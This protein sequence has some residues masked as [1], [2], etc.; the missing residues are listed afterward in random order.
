MRHSLFCG[1]TAVLGCL[2]H[3]LSFMSP[4]PLL[5]CTTHHLTVLHPLFGLYKQSASIG[6]C[7]W[8][9]FFPH[10]G[11]RFHPFAS[12]EL[13][14]Q[15]RS[16]RLPLCCHLSHSY[17]MSWHTGGKVQP[18]LPFY[19][20]DIMGQHNRMEGITFRAAHVNVFS[21]ISF[22]FLSASMMYLTWNRML[23]FSVTAIKYYCRIFLNL[24]A[25]KNL[26]HNIQ[27]ISSSKDTRIILTKW[28]M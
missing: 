28:K 17:N 9:H 22:H 6:E 13:P 27:V 20:H 12:Y 5:K 1:V 23:V 25:Y 26:S 24:L 4:S 16:V 3:G 15:I 8:V 7:Q 11:I 19:Q 2:E 14:C 18:L 10:G 21:C